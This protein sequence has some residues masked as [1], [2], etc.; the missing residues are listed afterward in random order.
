MF[1]EEEILKSIEKQI[2][3]IL[4]RHKAIISV[5]PFKSEID[6][7][8]AKFGY[9]VKDHD[10]VFHI[11]KRF[12]LTNDGYK[13]DSDYILS[14]EVGGSRGFSQGSRSF[15]EAYQVLKTFPSG[16]AYKSSRFFLED[17]E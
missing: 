1:T 3:G 5:K 12:V 10:R 13:Y 8:S 7:Y 4:K 6:D 2:P 17:E 14:Y 9:E 15:D 11:Y 16:T